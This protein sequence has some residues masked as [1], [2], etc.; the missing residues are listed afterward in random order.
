MNICISTGALGLPS[1]SLFCGMPLKRLFAAHAPS[2]A[3]AQVQL[4]V[5]GS[6]L[7]ALFEL[8][9]LARTIASTIAITMTSTAPPPIA[10]ARG[11]AWRGPDPPLERTGGGVRVA[12]SRRCC[13]ARLPLGIG[14]K[15]SRVL[16]RLQ[17]RHDQESDEQQEARERERLDLQVA[18]RLGLDPVEAA[19]GSGRGDLARVRLLDGP[20]ADEYVVDRGAGADDR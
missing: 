5:E 8:P 12:A 1:T 2:S 10:S 15:G 18:E 13:L 17:G 9:P 3:P 6:P 20:V 7:V 4:P 14:R 16:G 19:A 11:D